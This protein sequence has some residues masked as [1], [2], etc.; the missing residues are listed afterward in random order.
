M[1][2]LIT[3]CSTLLETQ[4]V[5]PYNVI[6]EVTVKVTF[7]VFIHAMTFKYLR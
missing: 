7:K 3:L 6:V 5:S 4:H 1:H 2:V